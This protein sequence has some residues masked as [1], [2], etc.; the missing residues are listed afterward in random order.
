MNKL[1]LIGGLVIGVGILAAIV[2]GKENNDGVLVVI[3][4]SSPGVPLVGAVV[5]AYTQDTLIGTKTIGTGGNANFFNV[6]YGY[7]EVTVD[8]AGYQSVTVDV[9]DEI[10][11]QKKSVSLTIQL[12]KS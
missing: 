1:K 7:Y 6:P 4:T 12:V 9:P 3:V 10:T 2:K 5:S 11:D 8:A